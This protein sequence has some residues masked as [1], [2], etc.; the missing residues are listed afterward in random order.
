MGSV[1]AVRSQRN[2]CTA[3]SLRTCASLILWR[4]RMSTLGSSARYSTTTSR[5]PGRNA[6][7]TLSITSKGYAS[8]W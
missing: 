1:R 2:G 3:I 8:S 6:R 5:P 7:T 4:G